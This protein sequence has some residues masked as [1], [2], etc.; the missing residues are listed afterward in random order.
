MSDA[1]RHSPARVVPERG[2]VGM[3]DVEAAPEKGGDV[4]HDLSDAGRAV[5]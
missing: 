5:H 2:Q 4:F 1:R 3:D